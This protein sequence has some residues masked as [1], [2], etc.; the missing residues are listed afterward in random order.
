MQTLAQ[1]WSMLEP[2]VTGVGPDDDRPRPA[3]ILFHGCGGLRDHLPKYAEAAKAAGW[4]AFIVDSYAPRGW[5]RTLAMAAVCTGVLLRGWERG[6]DVL[7]AIDGVSRRADVD[8]DKIALAGWSHG[9]WGIMEAMSADRSRPALGVADPGAVALDGVLATYLAYPYV[10]IAAPNRMRPW[11]HCPKTLAVIARKDHLTT[12]RNAERVHAMVR[13]CGAE[14]ET[15]VAE[16]THSFDEP[17]NAPPMRH[18]PELASEA[19]RRFAALLN[20]VA[21]APQA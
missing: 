3:V 18:D 11:R 1:R 5:N 2:A 15:W 8:P 13:D 16:G 21:V 17:M 14:V 10:G 20:D 19:V 4:R 6:G 12:V 7:A 9:G